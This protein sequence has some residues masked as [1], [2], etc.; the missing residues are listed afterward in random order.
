[1]WSRSSGVR[2][3]I[4]EVAGGAAEAIKRTEGGDTRALGWERA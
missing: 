3:G 2:Y 1:M 4:C